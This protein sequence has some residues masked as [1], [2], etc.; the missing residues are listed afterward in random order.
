M[1]GHGWPGRR[2]TVLCALLGGVVLCAPAAAQASIAVDDVQVTEGDAAVTATFTL[3]RRAP[4]L[5]GATSVAFETV[6]ATA[7]APGDF[8][9]QSGSRTF[10]SALLG[11]TQTQQVAVTVV[12]D[13]LDEPEESFRLV[14]AGPEVVDG[15]GIATIVDDDP[16]PAVGASDAA[17]ATEGGTASFA[18]TLAAPSGRDVSVAFATANGSATAGQDY[19]ATSGRLT[20]PAGATAATVP[21]A[22]LQDA[23]DEPAETFELRL[24]APGAATLGRAAATGTVLDDDPGP[25]QASPPGGSGQQRPAAP[26]PTSGSSPPASDAAPRLGI[27]S[28]RLRR[29]ATA[30]VT[31]SCPPE[32]GRCNGRVTLFSRPS[33]RSRIK[34][35]RHERRLGRRTFALDGGRTTT[36]EIA[37]ARRDRRLLQRVGRM[38]VRAV[39]VTRDGAGRTGVRRVTG[40][41]LR[42]T[43]HSSPSRR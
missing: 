40:T 18:I 16:P 30:L 25:A 43:A 10:A 23:A 3:T 27:G 33:A 37:L 42:R 31:I 34:A 38:A 29:P 11:A 6:G 35:L 19:A 2:R 17:A 1:R 41:L 26:P 22:L 8:V 32:A 12:G 36:L 28:P 13:R 15:E 5:A 14:L 39:A 4:L 9:V 20:I 21:V 24:S 7:L